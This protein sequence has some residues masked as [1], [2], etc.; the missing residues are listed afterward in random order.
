MGLG[1]LIAALVLA[2]TGKASNRVLFGSAVGFSILLG[3]LGLS[4]SFP[5]TAA[6]LL[7]FGIVS[8][9]F[10]TPINTSIQMTVPDELR[11]R[12][13]SIFFLLMAGSTPI[14]GLI[15]GQLA[16]RVGVPETLVIEAALRALGVAG[17]LLYHEVTGR[18]HARRTAAR[19][20][21]AAPAD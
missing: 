15:T 20:A 7:L 19:P 3:G 5:L 17:A 6:L 2:A 14:G 1:S 18:S 21:A 12:V 10:S 11:G 9:V 16:D 4:H 8:I 13:M